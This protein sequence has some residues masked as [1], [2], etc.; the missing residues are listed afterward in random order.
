MSRVVS[1]DLG[2]SRSTNGV[3]QHVR[4]NRWIELSM[5]AT[6]GCCNGAE[7]WWLGIRNKQS[8]IL[9]RCTAHT[10]FSDSR[11]GR[12]NGRPPTTRLRNCAT[13]LLYSALNNLS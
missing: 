12:N 1:Q 6:G 2:L 10:V 7:H 13:G 9:G 3:V 4:P 11:R 5:G 8:D